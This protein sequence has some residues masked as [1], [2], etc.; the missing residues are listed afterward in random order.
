[1]NALVLQMVSVLTCSTAVLFLIL[2]CVQCQRIEGDGILGHSG[3]FQFV[4]NL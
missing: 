4:T 3:L 2:N 1:M